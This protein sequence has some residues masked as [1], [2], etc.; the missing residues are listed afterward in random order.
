MVS[1]HAFRVLAVALLP[2]A[3]T[4]QAPTVGAPAPAIAATEWL[5]WQGPAPS[6]ETC[7]GKVVMLEFWGT[8]CGPCVRAMPAIQKLHDRYRDRGLVVLAISYEPRATMEPFLTKNAFTMP[9]GADTEKKTVAAY[10]IRGWPTTIV[11]DKEGKV[12]H[13]GS[14]YDAEAAVEQALGLEAGPAALLTAYFESQKEADKAKQRAALERL[15]EKATPDFDLAGWVRG[16]LPAETQS[17]EATPPAAPAGGAAPPPKPAAKGAPADELLRRCLVAWADPAQRTPLLQQLAAHAAPFDLAGFAQQAMAKAFPFETAEL[18]TMLKDKQYAAIVDAIGR[19]TPAPPV[20]ATA[21]KNGDL[22][23]FCK[24]RLAETKALAKRGL[25]AQ[26][27]LFAN[28]LPKDDAKNQQFQSELAMSGA[29][30]SADRKSIVGVLLGGEQVQRDRADA[31][32]RSHL[33]QV[34]VM[35]DLMAGK[36]PRVKEL[37]KLVEQGRSEIVGDLERRYGKPEPPAAK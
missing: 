32:V 8:W 34:V 13:V 18:Q 1:R 16:H 23:A 26:L 14:P 19:R 7:K 37:P 36:P 15:V 24:A 2:I 28:A 27:W 22:A 25:M 11:I 9:V 4:A 3:A 30:M 33:L 20:L 5:N 6:L 35:S 21:A 12:A 29:A 10:G 17:G 31:F